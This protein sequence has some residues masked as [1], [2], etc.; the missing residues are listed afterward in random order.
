MSP[1]SNSFFVEGT[2]S[3]IVS[4]MIVSAGMG[5]CSSCLGYAMVQAS[6]RA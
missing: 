4:P 3:L 6:E 2:E 1:A 5:M